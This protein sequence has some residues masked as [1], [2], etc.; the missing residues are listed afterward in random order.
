MKKTKNSETQIIKA[1]REY[2][3]GVTTEVIC[4]EY[5]ISR[6]TLYL[7]KKK[8]SGMETSQLKKLKDLE[9]ENRRLKHMYAE[10]SLD[11]KLLKEIIEKKL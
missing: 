1:I 3:S 10:L 9:D 8:Y 2:E 4:R 7:W 6:A 5:G 11:N